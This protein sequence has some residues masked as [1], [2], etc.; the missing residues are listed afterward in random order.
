MS[1]NRLASAFLALPLVL[2]LVACGS[3]LPPEEPVFVPPEPPA[4]VNTVVTLSV[5]DGNSGNLLTGSTATLTFS[6]TNA[7]SLRTLAGAAVTSLTTTTG[8]AQVQLASGTTP[9]AAAPLNFVV[10]VARS[11]NITVSEPVRLTSTANASVDLKML[12]LQTTAGAVQNLPSSTAAGNVTTATATT[13]GSLPATSGGNFTAAATLPATATQTTAV[14]ATVAVPTTVTAFVNGTTTPAA[15]GTVAAQIIV[16]DPKAATAAAVLPT[17]PAVVAT[18]AAPATVDTLANTAKIVLTDSAGNLINRFSSPITL[19]LGMPSTV[20]N[21]ATGTAFA[22][23]ETVPIFTYNEATAAWVRKTLN[24]GTPITGTVTAIDAATGNRTVSFQT[25]SLSWFAVVVSVAACS[26][27]QFT[28]SPAS[29]ATARTY[30][31][32]FTVRSADGTASPPTEVTVTVPANSTAGITVGPYTTPSTQGSTA[33]LKLFD[34]TG[35]SA[36]DT[37]VPVCGTAAG[38]LTAPASTASITTQVTIN[39]IPPTTAAP[40]TQCTVTSRVVPAAVTVTGGGKLL[41]SGTTPT[42][43]SL[44]VSGLPTGTAL[45]VG[46]TLGNGTA[47]PAQ[48]VTLTGA[49]STTAVNFTR[50]ETC[51]AGTGGTGGG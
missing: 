35:A 4:A 7:T 43:G 15:V 19:S 32:T 46:A 45:S 9:T 3:S 10:T 41:G 21:P 44:T 11:G 48:S 49:G 1:F 25:D 12:P 38:A 42:T 33:T 50:T 47:L 5:V 2:G 6:G 26:S 23:N 14:Q 30:T 27:T 20:R 29:A 34:S 22:L 36:L 16:A 17:P 24:N 51:V 28:L 39:Y 31:G 8:V 18:G 40:G 37:S 13:A